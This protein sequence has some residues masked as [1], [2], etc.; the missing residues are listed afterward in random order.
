MTISVLTS[1]CQGGYPRIIKSE[2]DSCIGISF[3]QAREINVI[4]IERDSY[5]QI[6]DSLETLNRSYEEKIVLNDK[7]ILN[8]NEKIVLKDTLFAKQEKISLV[9]RDE[10]EFLK[11]KIRF[12]NTM[13]TIFYIVGGSVITGLTTLLLIK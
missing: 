9:L 5:K 7:I 10:T 11:K 8:L 1:F 2:N 4:K 13:Q 3:D 6:S 12:K